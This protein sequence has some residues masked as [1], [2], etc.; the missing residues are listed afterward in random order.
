MMG[1][2]II[3][4]SAFCGTQ[5]KDAQNCII[6]AQP[7]PARL[8][9]RIGV[10]RRIVSS[11][12]GNLLTSGGTAAVVVRLG[13]LGGFEDAPLGFVLLSSDALGVDP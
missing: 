12:T 5:V 11:V 9:R 13:W 7:S 2:D 4:V 8:P 10:W 6:R 3:S 1:R